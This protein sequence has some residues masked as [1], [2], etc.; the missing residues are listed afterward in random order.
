MRVGCSYGTAVTILLLK[1]HCYDCGASYKLLGY[2][3]HLQYK[4]Q[5]IGNEWLLQLKNS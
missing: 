4:Q 5:L 2:D 1:H 3:G